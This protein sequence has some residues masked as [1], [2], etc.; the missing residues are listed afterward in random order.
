[1]WDYVPTRSYLC[2]TRGNLPDVGCDQNDGDRVDLSPRDRNQGTCVKTTLSGCD[3]SAHRAPRGVN[4]SAYR[5]QR[6][7]QQSDSHDETRSSSLRG[8]AWSVRSPSD[9]RRQG[10]DH[11]QLIS[12]ERWIEPKEEPR[13]TRDRGSIARRSWPIQRQIG[14]H[15]VAT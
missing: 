7:Y 14:N 1:M 8:G 3:L 11:K 10:S 4:R 15:G 9:G 2:R 13:S 6:E 12:I 5:H